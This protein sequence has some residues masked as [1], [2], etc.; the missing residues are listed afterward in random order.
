MMVFEYRAKVLRW[1]D[2]DTVDLEVDLGFRVRLEQRARL[3]GL[4]T[5]ELHS[6]D[7]SERATAIRA[8]MLCNRLAFPA[9]HVTIRSSKPTADDKY[10]RWLVE[11]VIGDGTNLNQELLNKGL[12]KP[13]DGSGP[14]PV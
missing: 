4:N 14:K 12:A 3:A 10:G 1:I 9:S 5:P 2:G 6:K 8:S 7:E 13:W 11:I